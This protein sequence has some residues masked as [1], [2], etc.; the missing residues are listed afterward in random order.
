MNG[1][2][3]RHLLASCVVRCGFVPD[4]VSCSQLFR[5]LQGALGDVRAALTRIKSLLQLEL[6]VNNSLWLLVWR[7]LRLL[8]LR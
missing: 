4:R 1:A 5:A 8:A 6:K 2:H 7:P 3:E